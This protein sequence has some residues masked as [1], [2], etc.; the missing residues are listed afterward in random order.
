MSTGPFL[1]AF[2]ETNNGRIAPIRI[3]PET[4]ALV[5]DGDTNAIPAG[6][7]DIPVS[8]KVSGG[9]RGVGLT[10]RTVTIKFDADVAGTQIVQGNTITLPWLQPA[11]WESF[12]PQGNL[13]GTYLSTPIR[14]VG[15]SAERIR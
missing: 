9:K 6:P 11:T 13:T 4:A 10:P 14:L 3:Q 15:K 5:I 2:Y 7:A 8:A 12:D 1:A